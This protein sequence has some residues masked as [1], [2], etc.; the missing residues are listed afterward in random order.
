MADLEVIARALDFIEAHL[1]EPISVAAMAEAVSY[2]L[3]YFCRM[4]KASTHHTPYDYLMRRRIAEAARDLLQ[5]ERKII[6]IAF[7]Y[8]FNNP[9]TFSRAVRRVLGMPPSEWRGRGEAGYRWLMPRITE[10][11][12]NH[13]HRGSPWRPTVENWPAFDL[14][15]AMTLELDD[16]RWCSQTARVAIWTWLRRMLDIDAAPG[17]DCYGVTYY[18]LDASSS[19]ADATVYV[20]GVRAEQVLAQG[21]ALIV[22]PLPALRYVRF[23]HRGLVRD[24][25]L[26][27]DY[28]YHTWM[29]QADVEAQTP[30][31]PALPLYL[32]HFGSVFPPPDAKDSEWDILV[33]IGLVESSGP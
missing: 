15:G 4:F 14:V 17:R 28:I 8:Q 25:G 12:L 30:L 7:D 10:A 20:A 19:V 23:T 1:R 26:T 13:I 3:Y 18:A 31:R 6:E 16:D 21:R 2:S 11:H 5:S 27:L 29:P 33:P 9:E 32:E 22:K 24:V